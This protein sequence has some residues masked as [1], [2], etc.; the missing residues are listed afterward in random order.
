MIINRNK[1]DPTGDDMVAEVCLAL[2]TIFGGRGQTKP[3]QPLQPNQQPPNQGQPS[4]RPPS[5]PLASATPKAAPVNAPSMP[6]KER[7]PLAFGGDNAT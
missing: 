3:F 1:K 5:K 4:S 2:D 6:I 7:F